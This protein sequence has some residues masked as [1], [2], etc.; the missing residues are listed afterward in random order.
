MSESETAITDSQDAPAATEGFAQCG[1]QPAPAQLC[2]F[3]TRHKDGS[4]RFLEAIITNRLDDPLIGGMV[5]DARDVTERKWSAERLQ[6][7]L[8]RC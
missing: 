7:S 5:M 4:W 2:Q 1:R 8:R 3:R 6:Q